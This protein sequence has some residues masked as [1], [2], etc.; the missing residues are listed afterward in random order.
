MLGG[1]IMRQSAPSTA[2]LL[3]FGSLMGSI[4]V[5]A[6]PRG[7]VLGDPGRVLDRAKASADSPAIVFA[8]SHPAS[9][10]WPPS[11]RKEDGGI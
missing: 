3:P 7:R 8:G 11:L 10:A 1:L 5:D 9:A 2:L 6:L 4:P